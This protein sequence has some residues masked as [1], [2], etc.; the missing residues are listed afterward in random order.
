MT[1][2]PLHPPL[3]EF[4]P[5]WLRDNCDCGECRDPA[6][7][8]KLFQIT[9]LPADLAVG[10]EQTVE[11][12][13]RTVHEVHWLPDG[14]R[15]RYGADWLG[16]TAAFVGAD[17]VA[18]A[19]TA[20]EAGER[21]DPAAR[22]DHGDGRTEDAKQLWTAPDL[23]D[24]LPEARWADY[25][26]DPAERLR[27][28][29]SV[30]RLG[31]ALLRDVPVREGQVLAVTETFGYV[32]ETNYGRIF[33]VR[34]EEQ[35]NNLAFTS[36]AIT[37]HTDNPYRDPVPTLQLLHCLDNSSPG[38]DSGLVDGFAAAALF[39]A[40]D[41]E[42]FAVLTRTPVPFRFA[43]GETELRADRPLIGVDP[44]GRIREVRFN[45]RSIGTLR[46]PVAETAAFY[47]AYRAFGELL[48]R[49]GRQLEFRLE[50]G[51]CLIFDNVRL[52]HARTAF[53]AGGSRRLQG[54]YADLDALDSTRAVLRRTAAA[55]CAGEVRAGEVRTEG[56]A[57]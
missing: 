43:D 11:W 41:P 51:D 37:P 22:S 16:G 35:P 26:A 1:T 27:L 23:A 18:D 36:V 6:T 47:A 10:S 38:G 44:R 8:Q 3:T 55:V 57:A 54:C 53:E 45:N 20:A 4:P 46:L 48:Q 5:V 40:E 9:D 30:A 52:L 19:G 29:D 25:L 49:P 17:D 39:R 12:N 7:G 56:G 15:S 33:E 42:G 32:R 50:P 34:V 24:R 2:A 28:L 21:T 14:H 13:G 31:F